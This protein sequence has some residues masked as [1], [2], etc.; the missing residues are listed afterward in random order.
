VDSA[1]R[2][3]TEPS[4]SCWDQRSVMLKLPNAQGLT[5]RT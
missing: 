2:R 1:A 3:C 5:W 4:V